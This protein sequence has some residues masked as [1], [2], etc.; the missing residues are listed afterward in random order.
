MAWFRNF[1]RCANCNRTW[2][3]EWSATCD[4]DCPHCGARHMSPYKS[5]DADG[6]DS[7]IELR[8]A[9][10]IAHRPPNKIPLFELRSSHPSYAAN[11]SSRSVRE[12]FIGSLNHK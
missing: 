12:L 10:S 9:N 11:S 8:S 7:W 2:T 5:E 1:Y 4:D 3:D 6:G